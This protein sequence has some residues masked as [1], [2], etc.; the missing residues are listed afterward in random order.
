[1]KTRVVKV[2]L[3]YPSAPLGTY[4][5]VA[6]VKVSLPKALP[7]RLTTLQKACTSQTFDADPGKCPGESIVGHAEVITPLLPVPLVGNA[8]FVSHASE[9]FPDLTI[10]LKGYGITVDLVG[11]TNIKN[12]ITT[13]T[14]KTTPDVP[15]SSFELNLPAQK[16]SALTANTNLCKSPLIMPTEFQAQ[17]GAELHQSTRISVTGCPKALTNRQK[18]QKALKACHKKHSKAR[19][20]C[21]AQAR[22]RYGAKRGKG[23][24][25]AG[26]G[27]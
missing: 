6:K 17:N 8:Y 20:S 4:A 11:S 27:K 16:Y 3:T 15:F 1:M 23:K 9:A 10:V 7:S 19:K 26:K 12:G 18:L 24:K 14:F 25:G 22:R 13:T 21:E 2:R 5:N